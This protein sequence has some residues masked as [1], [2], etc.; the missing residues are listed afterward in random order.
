MALGVSLVAPWAVVC[1]AVA[2]LEG[3]IALVG[4]EIPRVLRSR[5]R[6]GEILLLRDGRQGDVGRLDG[7]PGA[8]AAHALVHAGVAPAAALG[9]ALA[10]APA[11][12]PV[13]VVIPV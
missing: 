3:A 1:L 2:A 6:Q 10:L 12:V 5:G 13:D 4:G 7:A 11:A 9:T 8:I